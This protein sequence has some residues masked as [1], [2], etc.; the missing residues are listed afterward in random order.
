[1]RKLKELK[2]KRQPIWNEIENLRKQ[3]AEGKEFT[4]EERAKF[5]SL[6]DQFLKITNEIKEE[7]K[8]LRME[9]EMAEVTEI[10]D[11]NPKDEKKIEYKDAFGKWMRSRNGVPDLSVE[12][13][14]ALMAEFRAQG[15]GSG[16]IGGYTVPED[17]Y[18]ALEV[19]LK[20]YCNFFDF[21]TVFT[22]ESGADMPY[23][24]NNDTTNRATILG[25][26]T[27]ITDNYDL[28]FGVTTFKSWMY[29]P[30]NV[31]LVSLQLMQDS[32]FNIEQVIAAAIGER[33]G[34]GLAYDFTLGNGS[35]APQGITVG[36]AA[37]GVR[38]ARTAF[39]RAKLLDL[40]FAL[41]PA[42]RR[43][44]KWMFNDATLKAILALEDGDNR[45]LY[46]MSPIVGQPDTI[47]G[48]QYIINT[49]MA[50]SGTANNKS[51][52]FGKMDKYFIRQVK[53]LSLVRFDEKY[54]NAAQIG[55]TAFGRW[56]G[57]VMDAGTKPIMYGDHA[58][59]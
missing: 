41:D 57:R 43:D 12:E 4:S 33:F 26:N 3:V 50:G 55:W 53:G 36:A 22:T 46:Q 11:N 16:S 56:D 59:T 6:S 13:R 48:H 40:K 5:D 42:Y 24:T 58:A 18:R 49:D 20:Y 10:R 45:P 35:T 14:D 8:V 32:A 54:M 23:P 17:F 51:V 39:T 28:T 29:H 21:A 7:E 37:S 52:L 9:A 44:A 19:A 25:E 15:V 38:F 2:E 1:M 30:R 47:E 34:R 27:A 31:F